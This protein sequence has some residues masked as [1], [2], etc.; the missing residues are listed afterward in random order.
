MSLRLRHVILFVAAACSPITPFSRDGG[1]DGGST[2]GGSATAGGNV[3]GGGS[4]G[5]STSTTG[6]GTSG[7]VVVSVGGGSTA[8]GASA[9]GRAGGSAG[10]TTAGGSAVDAGAAWVTWPIPTRGEVKSISGV[11]GRIYATST[12]N[13]LRSVDGGAFVSVTGFNNLA[14]RAVEVTPSLVIAIADTALY[15]CSGECATGAQFAELRTGNTYDR[16][17]GSCRRGDLAYI[18]GDTDIDGR[19]LVLAFDGGSLE[20]VADRLAVRYLTH[21]LVTPS[22]LVVTG[23]TG[24]ARLETSGTTIVESIDLMGQPAQSW[25]KLTLDETL[26]DGVLVSRTQSGMTAAVRFD[27]GWQTLPS[28]AAANSAQDV[29]RLGPGQFLVGVSPRSASLYLLNGTT[30]SPYPTQP[31]AD[32]LVSDLLELDGAIWAAGTLNS[33]GIITRG[34]R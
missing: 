16:L 2:G 33:V 4:S 31:P 24:V 20:R 13:L 34:S 30:W 18:V 8:G 23:D 7:G 10:G 5:G 32:M 9:G 27:G 28:N 19:G 25:Y 12:P 21:C 1:V 14:L 3:I 11:P 6:G 17:R 22:A 15:V 29:V 26:S